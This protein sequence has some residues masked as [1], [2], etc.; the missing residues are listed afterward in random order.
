MLTQWAE[1]LMLLN[2]SSLIGIGLESQGICE[3]VNLHRDQSS[4]G[5]ELTDP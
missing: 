3:I 5:E 4:G 1:E 2:V